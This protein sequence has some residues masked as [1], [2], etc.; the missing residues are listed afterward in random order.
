MDPG[1]MTRFP[2]GSRLRDSLSCGFKI[3]VSFIYRSRPHD[4]ATLRIQPPCHSFLVCPC[5][6]TWLP[7]G[8]RLHDMASLWIQVAI[9]C[10]VMNPGPMTQLPPGYRPNATVSLWNL[11]PW[12]LF[13]IGSGPW[14]GVLVDSGCIKEFCHGSSLH[15]ITGW[16]FLLDPGSVKWP[17]PWIQPQ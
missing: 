16:S 14:H 13:L 3:N 15:D 5:F 10:C 6:I 9:I 12:N 4:M 2:C 1:S 17:P 11:A 8:S 7:L